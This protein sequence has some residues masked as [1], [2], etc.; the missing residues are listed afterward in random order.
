MRCW[1][2]GLRRWQLVVLGG[3]WGHCQ[4]RPHSVPLSPKQAPAGPARSSVPVEPPLPQQR[5]APTKLPAGVPVPAR[6]GTSAPRTP[7]PPPRL[8][9]PL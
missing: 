1:E 9:R 3:G 6:L 8:S 4:A 5:Q 7:A 2:D